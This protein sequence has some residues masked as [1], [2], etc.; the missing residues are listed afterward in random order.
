MEGIF[1]WF[2]SHDFGNGL[3]LMEHSYIDNNFVDAVM[4]ELTEVGGARLAWAG[5][6]ADDEPGGDSIYGIVDLVHHA[7]HQIRPDAEKPVLPHVRWVLNHDK[8]EYVD[9]HA[10]PT[11]RWG[12]IHPVPLL[13]AEGNGRGGG[14]FHGQN[15]LIG[16]W[17]RD[18]IQ[19]LL[20]TESWTSTGWTLIIPNFTEE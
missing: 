7:P 12:A 4:R 19:V 6:Y 15:D 13:T 3:K 14:D 2:Y 18:R 5:D 20:P 1:G 10:V 17:A 16:T 8:H 9:L 11:S